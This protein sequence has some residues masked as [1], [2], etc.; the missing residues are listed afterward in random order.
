[1][2]NALVRSAL[3]IIERDG[4][5]ALSLRAVAADVGVS[6]A[7]PAH[8]FG[9][10]KAL[11][12]ALAAIGY[13]RFAGAMRDR[14][15]AAPPDPPAQMRAAAEG[16]LA[17]AVANPALFRLMFSAD[18][19]DWSDAAL[20]AEARLARQQL[21]EICAPAAERLGI[22]GDAAAR[23]ALER[24]VWSDIHGRA[25]LTIDGQLGPTNGIE[26]R[27]DI[28]ELIFSHDPRRI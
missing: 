12:S 21:E 28:A 13:E 22:G 26:D 1:L 15:S 16:Y 8:H 2:R 25:H 5:D 24:L 9:T 18:R 27:L 6:H 19:L 14:R 11:R 20:I 10:L 3:A 4:V 7:A 23:Q 17:F